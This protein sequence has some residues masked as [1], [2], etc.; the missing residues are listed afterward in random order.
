MSAVSSLTDSQLLSRFREGDQAAFGQLYEKYHG[1]TYNFLYRFLKSPDLSEDLTQEVFIKFWDKRE[2]IG[3]LLSVKSYLLTMA[4]NHAFNF[5][6]RAGVDRNAMAEIIKHYPAEGNSLEN[7]L[8]F[9]DYKRYLDEILATLSPQSREVFRLCRQE[10]RTY[11][12]TAALLGISR[13]T[14]KKHMVR[15]M[16]ILSEAVQR[17]LGI[18]LTLLLACEIR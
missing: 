12:E 6:K 2:E 16:K 9:N 13:N 3:M 14:V 7:A 8:H 1:V 5:L 15:S 10:G 17:D 4:K 18:S 11:D